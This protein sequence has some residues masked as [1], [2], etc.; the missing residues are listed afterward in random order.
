MPRSEARGARLRADL[1]RRE[2][3]AHG[4]KVRIAV[5]QLEVAGE[6]FDTVDLPPALHLDG[7]IAAA[8]VAE[9]QVDRPDRG[10]MLPAHQRP[11]VTEGRGVLGE[12]RLEVGLHS[13]LLQAGV[14]PEVVLAVVQHLAD[15]DL[16]GVTVPA[17]HLPDL[18]DQGV[19]VGGGGREIV[20]GGGGDRDRAWRVHPVERLVGAIV[21][22]DRHRPVGLDENQPDGHREVG[23]QL[24]GVIDLAAGNHQTHADNLH[25]GATGP[26]R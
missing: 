14:D 22:M 20:G 1:L 12:Q 19:D 2:H 6:L 4:R 11:P 13:V 15:R 9:Q 25:R 26:R 16:Q 3:P 8:G 21:G 23:R 17:A 5:H 10:R 18:G 7:H 24:P